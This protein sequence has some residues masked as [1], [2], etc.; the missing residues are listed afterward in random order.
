M[1]RLDRR[2][3]TLSLAAG[4]AL[5]GVAGAEP[6]LPVVTL[7][8]DSIAAGFGLP[9]DQGLAAA[10]Q[11]ELS[12]L[13][14]AAAVR[15]A[16]LPGDTSAGGQGRSKSAVKSDTAV[17]VVEFGG[18][19]RAHK[20]APA[21]TSY[22]LD[23][24]VRDLKARGMT[25]VLLGMKVPDAASDAEAFNAVF[26]DV[27]KKNGVILCDDYMAGV[28]REMRQPD[29]HPNA[30]GEKVLA[31]KIAPFVMQAMKARSQAPAQR[32]SS[33]RTPG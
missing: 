18:N 14:L 11:A 10:L 1:M 7:F 19:D 4:V 21:I 9:P 5:G 17:C 6:A 26:A 33:R 29:G 31:A 22:C 20:L 12:R 3:F 32:G 16:G 13:G 15:N 30:E 28:T 25:V 27:A 2:A 8:G 23:A 24:I